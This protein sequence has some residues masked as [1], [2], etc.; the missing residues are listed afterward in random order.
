MESLGGLTIDRIRSAESME[1]SLIDV[2]AD[3]RKVGCQQTPSS[4]GY[5]V[6][7]NLQTVNRPT[8][9]V[10]VYHINQSYGVLTSDTKDVCVHYSCDTFLDFPVRPSFEEPG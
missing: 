2:V 10:L 8:T 9:S 5:A 1:L 4:L 6:A 3:D 7:S